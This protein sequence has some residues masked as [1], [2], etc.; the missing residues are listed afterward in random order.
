[1]VETSIFKIRRRFS[2][3]QVQIFFSPWADR[4]HVSN[5]NPERTSRPNLSYLPIESLEEDL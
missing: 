1:M 3:N 2:R 5:Q 4:K